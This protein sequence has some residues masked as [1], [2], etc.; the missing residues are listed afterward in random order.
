MLLAAAAEVC[1][2]IHHTEAAAG[3]GC[4]SNADPL[5]SW[6]FSMLAMEAELRVLGEG[7]YG[8]GGLLICSVGCFYDNSQ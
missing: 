5:Y 3:A 1:S 4:R 8:G 2:W 7:G 6:H